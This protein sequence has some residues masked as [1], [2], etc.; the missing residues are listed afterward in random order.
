MKLIFMFIDGVGL[1]PKSASNP[2]SQA[3]MPEFEKHFGG[4]LTAEAAHV[5]QSGKV[6]L[7][8]DAQLG[9]AG[10]GQS[11]TGQFAIY[12]S[13]NGAERFGR[14]YG[15]HL[16]STLKEPLA[17]E[18]IFR[19]LSARGKTVYYANAYPPRLIEWYK[20]VRQ[21]GKIRSSVLF[22]AAMMENVAVQS[23]DETKRGEAIS[24]DITNRWWG[25]NLEEGD[26]SVP[27]ISPEEAARNLLA[28]SQTHDAVFYEFFLTDLA[29]HGR[30]KTSVAEILSRL[31]GFW[32]TLWDN[33]PSDTLFVMT[34]DHGNLEDATQSGHTT[35]PVPLVAIGH[36]AES[37][38]GVTD[39]SGV[40]KTILD[41]WQP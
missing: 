16:P 2:L 14:H 12:T 5:V 33:L 10:D 24:G 25:V 19:K 13:L 20:D 1:A 21:H 9:M 27:L 11:G 17:Q 6:F 8:I 39:I 40:M 7:P 4:K 36:N 32:G 22:E 35:N 26:P 41:N 15:P 37:L 30:I 31:D 34:S 28:L 23:V 38:R 18:N 29:G 3:A